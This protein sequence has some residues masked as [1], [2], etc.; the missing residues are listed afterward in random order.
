MV[1]IGNEV[2]YKANGKNNCWKNGKVYASPNAEWSYF[3]LDV[4]PMIKN[5]L[6]TA[7]KDGYL[8]KTSLDQLYITGMNLGWEIPGSYDA[9]MEVKDFSIIGTRK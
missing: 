1:G 2:M 7:H 4:L 6:D 8:T 9:T 3:S 5:A